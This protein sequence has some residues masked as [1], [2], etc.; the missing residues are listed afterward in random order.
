MKGE[1]KNCHPCATGKPTKK[2]FKSHFDDAKY[3]DEMVH[4]LKVVVLLIFSIDFA[5]GWYEL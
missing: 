4:F 1:I 2:S 5:C 3:A